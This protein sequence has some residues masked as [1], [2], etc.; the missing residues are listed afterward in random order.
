MQR[1]LT[2]E[3]NTQPTTHHVSLLEITPQ[4]NHIWCWKARTALTPDSILCFIICLW[5]GMLFVTH[6]PPYTPCAAEIDPKGILSKGPLK[7]S[8][9]NTPGFT[10]ASRVGRLA[11]RHSQS[12]DSLPLY[13]LVLWYQDDY[14]TKNLLKRCPAAWK[15]TGHKHCLIHTAIPVLGLHF[16]GQKTDMTLGQEQINKHIKDLMA[17]GSP[18]I[19]LENDRGRPL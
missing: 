4:R 3:L 12:K 13:H 17:T 18:L 19:F 11:T 2:G 5:L 10:L 16:V 1:Q 9:C 15:Y 6:T 8:N 14:W 7:S